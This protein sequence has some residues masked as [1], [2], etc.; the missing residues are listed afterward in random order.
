MP[1]DSVAEIKLKYYNFF[2]IRPIFVWIHA[3]IQ[4]ILEGWQPFP[5]IFS[6]RNPLNPPYQGDLPS[7]AL[8][9]NPLNPPYQGDL[10]SPDP[11]NSTNPLNPPYQGTYILLI[12]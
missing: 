7:P 9:T 5:L 3:A 6:A 4:Q 2:H 1:R 12:C 8:C 11:S 10:Y